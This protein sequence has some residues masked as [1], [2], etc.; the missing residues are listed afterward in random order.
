MTP[1]QGFLALIAGLVLTVS[2][3]VWLFG[4]FALIGSGVVITALALLVPV[5]SVSAEPV[6][7]AVPPGA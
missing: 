3:L 7:E 1:A 4:P 2:G 5:R 6:D